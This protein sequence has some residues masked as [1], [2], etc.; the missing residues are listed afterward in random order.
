VLV[1]TADFSGATFFDVTDPDNATE[2][3]TSAVDLLPV[4]R[5]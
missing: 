1:L 3:I 2:A 4:L 5:E